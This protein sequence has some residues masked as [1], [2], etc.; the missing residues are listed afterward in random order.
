MISA[1]VRSATDGSSARI[2]SATAVGIAAGSGVMVL[3]L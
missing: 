1:T 3:L 2:P